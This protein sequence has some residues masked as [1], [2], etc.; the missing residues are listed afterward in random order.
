MI[1]GHVA[2]VRANDGTL[3][4]A[5]YD[6]RTIIGERIEIE[7]AFGTRAQL[8]MPAAQVLGAFDPTI[9]VSEWLDAQR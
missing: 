9:S 4:P 2:M 3:S 5:R 7:A 1:L 8:V 6:G